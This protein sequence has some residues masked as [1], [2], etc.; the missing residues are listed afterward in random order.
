MEGKVATKVFEYN[1]NNLIIIDLDFSTKNTKDILV[2]N[3]SNTNL[4]ESNTKALLSIF[5]KY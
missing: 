4:W 1:T 2:N 5:T 3:F